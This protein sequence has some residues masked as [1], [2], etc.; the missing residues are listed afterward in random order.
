V[1]RAPHWARA[2]VTF[3][4]IRNSGLRHAGWLASSA[5]RGAALSYSAVIARA[6]KMAAYCYAFATTGGENHP[7]PGHNHS[8]PRSAGAGS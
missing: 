3:A 2:R 5:R 1:S 6:I 7:A 8:R 4:V